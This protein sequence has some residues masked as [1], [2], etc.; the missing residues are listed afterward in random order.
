MD[1]TWEPTQGCYNILFHLSARHAGYAGYAGLRIQGTGKKDVKLKNEEVPCRWRRW[2]ISDFF[3][4]E[5]RTIAATEW[6]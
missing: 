6:K 1:S 2:Q 5:C 3:L 4:V